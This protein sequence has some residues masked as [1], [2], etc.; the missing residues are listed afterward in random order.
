MRKINLIGCLSQQMKIYEMRACCLQDLR[1]GACQ[2][3]HDEGAA[4]VSIALYRLA[5]A[6]Q[7][8]RACNICNGDLNDIYNMK[9]GPG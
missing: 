1:V 2:G 4:I 7:N 9:E 6:G 3:S 5:A 8:R